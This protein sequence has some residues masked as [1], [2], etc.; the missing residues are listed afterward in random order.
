MNDTREDK[1]EKL[2]ELIRDVRVAMLTTVQDDG[3]LRSRPMAVQG[4]GFEDGSIW[5]F[6]GADSPKALE[7][8]KDAHVNVSF[9]EPDDQRFVS[10]M[11]RGEL[12]R[13]R[14][15]ME[16]L[17]SAVLKAWFPK[18]L[19]DPELALIR[20]RVEG[21]EYWE[22]PSSGVVHL[23]GLAKAALTGE[24]LRKPGVNGKVDLT[25]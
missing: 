24:P 4:N 25:G 23:I 15:T 10:I 6:T 13:D 5:F 2:G 9:A 18:G 14:A 20:V 22:S 11:G 3:T 17:W 7:I 21:A 19:D 12:V 8:R 16:R 1:L